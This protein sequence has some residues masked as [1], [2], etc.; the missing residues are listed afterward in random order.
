MQVSENLVAL[1]AL[2]FTTPR[3]NRCV[4]SSFGTS[5][6]LVVTVSERLKALTEEE[7][8]Q[9]PRIGVK[10]TL[11]YTPRLEIRIDGTQVQEGKR[12]VVKHH[13]FILKVLHDCQ[14][15]ISSR[16]R[17]LRTR[18]LVGLP[19]V[20]VGLHLGKMLIDHGIRAVDRSRNCNGDLLKTGRRAGNWWFVGLEE[21]QAQLEL[22]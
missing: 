1:K 22:S 6:G 11:A 2:V 5:T 14:Y 17:P 9:D 12:V 8:I 10:Y 21:L 7:G 16:F 4:F 13:F 3:R 18:V 15:A 19:R 20:L